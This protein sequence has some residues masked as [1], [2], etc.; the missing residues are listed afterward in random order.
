MRKFWI[1]LCGAVV[2]VGGM[3]VTFFACFPRKYMDV[4]DKYANEYNLPTYMVMSVINIESGFN[5]TARSS[6]GAMGLMQLKLSTAKDMANGLGVEVDEVGI[7]DVDLNIMLGTKYLAYLLELFD[8]NETNALASYNWGLQNVRD[9]M[10]AG[11]VDASGTVTNIQVKETRD[12]LKRYGL[13]RFI[14]KNLHGV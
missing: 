12:Y 13:N 1:I 3:L 8:G 4:V 7:F 2:F 6:A 9:W 10:S 14:Y 11:N 5:P